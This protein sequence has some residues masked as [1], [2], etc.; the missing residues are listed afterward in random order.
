MRWK[1]SVSD[2][3][4]NTVRR[5]A[6][7]CPP[8]RE[9]QEDAHDQRRRR[10]SHRSTITEVAFT[11]PVASAG[12]QV[13]RLGRLAGDDRD[14]PRRLGHVDLDLREE[15]VHLYV[16][17]DASQPVAGAELVAAAA[18]QTLD[19]RSGNEPA[20]R[21]VTLRTDAAGAIP[22]PERVDT[23][24]ERTH[25]SVDVSSSFTMFASRT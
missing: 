19:L 4:A 16:P 7:A 22:A 1:T 24:A 21:R 18:A 15:T 12:P 25:A 14:D 13:E 3:A 23:H 8:V 5:G 2:A 20:I 9:H 10:A 11:M 6:A 17:H